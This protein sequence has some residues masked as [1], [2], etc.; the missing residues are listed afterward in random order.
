MIL[1]QAR[2]P[3]D[4]TA[5]EWKDGGFRDS[6]SWHKRIWEAFPGRPSE[7]KRDFLTRIDDTGHNFRLLILS[8]EPP[9]RPDWCPSADWQSKKINNSFFLHPQYRFSLLVNPTRKKV[10]RDTKGNRR[11]NGKRIPITLRED[12]VDWL[13]R[14]AQQ[15]GFE[16]HE[17][18]SLKIIPH[19]KRHFLKKGAAGIHTAT[20]FIGG[21]KVLDPTKFQ[22]AA[23]KGIGSAKAFGFGMLCLAPE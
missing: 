19:A 18:N 11:K 23:V 10:V 9:T 4:V 14:K 7:A 21:L 17:P 8:P 15:H 16:I 2:V 20:E 12:L 22:E 13:H 5:R 1:T 3:Y 6:Y